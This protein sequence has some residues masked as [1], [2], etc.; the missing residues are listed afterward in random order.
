MEF[1]LHSELKITIY[2]RFTGGFT[3][4]VKSGCQHKIS[5][6]SILPSILS[7]SLL[8]KI[9]ADNDKSQNNSILTYTHE[10]VTN[11]LGECGD[12]Q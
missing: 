3:G 8:Q 7:L 12:G 2:G 10:S 9:V 4:F 5:T 11:F 6:K 1:H